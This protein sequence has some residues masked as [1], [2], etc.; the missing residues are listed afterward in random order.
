[1]L[2]NQSAQD[3]VLDA[4]GKRVAF[5]SYASNLVPGDNNGYGDVFE[6][7]LPAGTTT[8]ADAVN[9]VLGD[10]G[11]DEPQISADGAIVAFHSYSTTLL[12]A[13][14]DTNGHGDI[15]TR[16]LG[17]SN[18]VLISR[19][20]GVAG[21]Q[22]NG[23]AYSPSMSDN[24]QRVAFETNATNLGDGDVDQIDDVHVRDVV[25]ATTTLV[26]RATGVAGAKGDEQSTRPAISGDGSAVA[27]SSYA[28]NLGAVSPGPYGDGERSPLVFVR[29]LGP[30]TTAL[31][32]RASGAAGA[33]DDRG[34]YDPSI[35]ANGTGVVWG[36]GSG[37]LDPLSTG[38]FSEVFQRDMAAATTRLVSRPADAS[39]RPGTVGVAQHGGN[40]VSADGRYVA[41]TSSSDLGL[42]TVAGA[43]GYVR[44]TLTGATTLVSRASGADGTPAAVDQY[45]IEISADGTHIAFASMS[46]A[47]GGDNQHDQVYVRDLRTNTTTLASV[48]SS[49]QPATQ[50]ARDPALDQDGDRV[51][52][53]SGDDLAPGDGNGQTDAYV[54][55][56]TAS[57]TTLASVATNG[58]AGSGGVEDWLDLSA[59]G[60][61]LAFTD[62]SDN[63]VGGDSN[64][65]P[66]VFVRDLAAGTTTVVDTLPNGQTPKT[67]ALEASISADGTRVSFEAFDVLVPG[68]KPATGEVYVRDLRT[69]ALTLASVSSDG[70][71]AD[72][73]SFI[74]QISSD[75]DHVVF[76]S[77]A[78]NLPG[79][80]SG[81]ALYERDLTAAT[82][83]VVG[84]ADGSTD[85]LRGAGTPVP[86]ADGGCVAFS[87]A[88]PGVAPNE[89]GGV[90]FNQIYLRTV[91]GECPRIAP[92][93]TITA[94]PARHDPHDQRDVRVCR[95]RTRTCTSSA[96][97]TAV[98]LPH[99]P[100]ACRRPPS[101]TA[102]IVSPSAR[103]TPPARSTRRPR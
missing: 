84:A 88:D 46:P 54:R 83:A 28:S 55:D 33:P 2:G 99:V 47:V 25:A 90:Q 59:D 5:A 62:T 79:G 15:F 24:G 45:R 74:S 31:A 3:C 66:D 4:D 29:A 94:G 36:S 40:A 77:P 71:P 10:K 82:T 11:A 42:G 89:F 64:T 93:T 60:T 58:A 72:S 73:Q 95:Q 98:R 37:S 50:G 8:A 61:R 102:C 67:G 86:S 32:S 18:P 1:M 69:G 68:V 27:F 97:S 75:G 56:L 21:A 9:G 30:R 39:G 14:G 12:G 7:N 52:F 53:R 20:D 44:D 34:A 23:D 103:S 38:R 17:P 22:S 81:G 16:T 57:T 80:P 85:P 96:R 35:T 91:R 51:A 49:G 13:G 19:A 41:F 63:L 6:R 87:A 78:K 100:R 76:Y 48:S 101:P 65:S 26:S 70:Q 43:L 92:D